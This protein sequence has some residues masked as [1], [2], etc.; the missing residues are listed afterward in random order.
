MDILLFT[1]FLHPLLLM[2]NNHK[3]HIELPLDF[4][5]FLKL[6]NENDVRYLLYGTP[7][8][9]II[10][11]KILYNLNKLL[12]PLERLKRLILSYRDFF[13]ILACFTAPLCNNEPAMEFWVEEPGFCKLFTKPCND[14]GMACE[15]PTFRI[16]KR[17]GQ[18][19]HCVI[20]LR[21][22]KIWKP[23]IDQ[24]LGLRGDHTLTASLRTLSING[25]LLSV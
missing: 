18:I 6:L 12:G 7:T 8:F 23:L 2:Q 15:L 16:K 5:E 19:E 24:H 3:G 13:S 4:K 21:C 10:P 14:R 20:R 11:E 22:G 25:I 9:Q 1:P 17:L